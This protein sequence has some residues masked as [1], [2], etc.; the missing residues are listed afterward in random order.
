M[1]NNVLTIK[2]LY[3]KYNCH[4]NYYRLYNLTPINNHYNSKIN[5]ICLKITDE[6]LLEELKNN[7]TVKEISIKYNLNKTSIRRRINKLGINYRTKKDYTNIFTKEFLESTELSVSRLCEI[8][9]CDRHTIISYYKKHN[10]KN[11]NKEFCKY[12]GEPFKTKN[13]EYKCSLNPDNSKIILTC[14]HCNFKGSG[15]SMLKYHFDNC[16]FNN[17]KSE[18]LINIKN[19]LSLKEIADK[20]NCSVTTIYNK[21]NL[22][23]IKY[24]TKKSL[25]EIFTKDFLENTNYSISELSK[26]YNC[27][28]TTIWKY[29]NKHDIKYIKNKKAHLILQ[30]K[31]WL[32]QKYIIENLSLT[33][34]A[35]EL[36]CGTNLI[37]KY[38]KLHKIYQKQRFKEKMG[39][40]FFEN[41]DEKIINLYTI[42]KYSCDAISLKYKCSKEYVRDLLIKN[43][44][45]RNINSNKSSIEKLV[46]DILD[47]LN[48]AYTTNTKKIIPPF[49]I[50][51]F[52]E[53]YNIA[54][55]INGIYYHSQKFI[56]KNYHENKRILC[57]K[58][59]IRLIQLFEDDIYL[60]FNIIRKFLVNVFNKNLSSI[61]ARKCSIITDISL[62]EKR[63]FMEENHIQGYG[64][65]NYSIGLEYNNKLMALMLFNGNIL[66]RYA[67]SSNV[68]GGFSKLLIN[69]NL[70]EV[71]TFCDLTM[72]TGKLYE[73]NGFIREYYIPPDYKYVYK[74]VRHHKFNF[75][76]IRF[77]ND[78]KLIY[79]EGLTEFELAKL[80]NIQRIYDAGK[81]KYKWT[82]NK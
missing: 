33:N 26:L 37:K 20:Q 29:I 52:A 50:D 54:I 23:N 77:K 81:I 17:T 53:E 72:F 70:N 61:Y 79:Q 59:N 38:L 39:T 62:N 18:L 6:Q 8:Y 74:N 55:E 49:E 82:R 73:K 40:I 4:N 14:P 2:E 21:L 3:E 15:P 45:E 12:C 46:C 27:N 11:N 60:K 43:N 30:N 28:Q 76:K 71:Y 51:I 68:V 7:L 57:E 80:N 63:K 1:K 9:N 78:D 67:T 19:K 69:S 31:K 34:I 5:M 22:Y 44:I 75:R 16:K 10:L 24:S 48:I 42:E 64:K 66:T 47:E 56:N 32:Y 25:D 35:K 36:N 58:K 41:L 13:H 65:S